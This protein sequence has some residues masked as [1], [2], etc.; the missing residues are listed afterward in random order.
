MISINLSKTQSTALN[1]RN[2][3]IHSIFPNRFH[4]IDDA[5]TVETKITANTRGRVNYHG[6]SWLAE[7][8]NDET[9]VC[10]SVVKV[11]GRR[12]LTLLVEMKR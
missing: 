8:F 4:W 11:I 6:T 1:R 2:P 12:N 9:L 3:S 10:N 7:S 5:A